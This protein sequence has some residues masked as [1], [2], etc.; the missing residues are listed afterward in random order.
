MERDLE[1]GCALAQLFQAQAFPSWQSKRA[2][3]RGA[4]SEAASK[5][6]G[7]LWETVFEACACR[8]KAD[9]CRNDGKAVVRADK[10]ISGGANVR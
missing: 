6:E 5:A 8:P 1:I 10:L 7:S 2:L 4:Q 9:G 3:G